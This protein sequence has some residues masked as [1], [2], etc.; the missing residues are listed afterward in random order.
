MSFT[1]IK[2]DAVKKQWNDNVDD[3]ISDICYYYHNDLEIF[4]AM[5]IEEVH[6]QMKEWK[7]L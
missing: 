7:K 3:T 5:N 4:M 1:L 6:H 2:G